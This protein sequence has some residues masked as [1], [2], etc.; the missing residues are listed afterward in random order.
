MNP[1][2]RKLRFRTECLTKYLCTKTST[3]STN[4][5]LTN[6][7]F[8]IRRNIVKFE[9]YGVIIFVRNEKKEKKHIVSGS[10]MYVCSIFPFTSKNVKCDFDEIKAH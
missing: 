2:D 10:N 5:H 7:Y 4:K 1:Q 9:L 6:V 8:A 3:F